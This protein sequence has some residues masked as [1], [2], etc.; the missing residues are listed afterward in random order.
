MIEQVM[1][2]I[3]HMH[4]LNLLHRDIKNEN[5]LVVDFEKSFPRDTWKDK[6]KLWV[7]IIDFDFVSFLNNK[8]MT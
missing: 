4:K 2:A 8:H 3:I 5:L 6:N 7:K 1:S